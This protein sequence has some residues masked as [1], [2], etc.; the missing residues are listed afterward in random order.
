MKGAADL[1]DLSRV[2]IA[3]PTKSIAKRGG[4]GIA[5]PPICKI[6]QESF[7]DA[8]RR[9]FA[10]EWLHPDSGKVAGESKSRRCP[11]LRSIAWTHRRLAADLQK[12]KA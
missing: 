5:A 12:W 4:V 10:R 2:R 9:P 8:G 7:A 11:I 1:S 3:A 6:V